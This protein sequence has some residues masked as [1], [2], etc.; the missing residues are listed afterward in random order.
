MLIKN[1]VFQINN[2]KI[3]KFV[4]DKEELKKGQQVNL[5]ISIN[6]SCSEISE[7]KYLNNMEI[8]INGDDKLRLNIKTNNVIQVF[9][10]SVDFEKELL[11]EC[12]YIIY[13]DMKRK[14]RVMT[15]GFGISPLILPEL[16]N[17]E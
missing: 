3:Q 2:S 9:S 10:D 6:S 4:F 5:G 13:N 14:I 1:D 8:D 12:I 17:L 7:N 11:K 15:R 16:Q